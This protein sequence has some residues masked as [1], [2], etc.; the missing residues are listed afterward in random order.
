MGTLVRPT[1]NPVPWQGQDRGVESF[2]D[3]DHSP[4]LDVWFADIFPQSVACLLLFF[5]LSFAE[6]E[7]L[8]L[9]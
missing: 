2:V 8:I 9:V 1:Q 4:S 3:V 7:F 5:K 6:N